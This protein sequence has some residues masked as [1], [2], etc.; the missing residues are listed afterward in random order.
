VFVA[1]VGQSYCHGFLNLSSLVTLYATR[2]KQAYI[3]AS[4][5]ER[6]EQGFETDR[7]GDHIPMDEY[8]GDRPPPSG[9]W[10]LLVHSRLHRQC[11][12]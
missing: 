2:L 8:Y 10:G 11:W 5:P 7:I 12:P 1:L 4:N 6:A 3:G 9:P